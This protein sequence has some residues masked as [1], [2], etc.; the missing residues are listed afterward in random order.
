MCVRTEYIAL[1]FA[2]STNGSDE[3]TMNCKGGKSECREVDASYVDITE[4]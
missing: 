3:E 1:S 2:T 4:D